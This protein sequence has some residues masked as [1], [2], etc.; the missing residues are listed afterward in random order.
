MCKLSTSACASTLS[1]PAG[2]APNFA[3]SGSPCA[4]AGSNATTD[5][6]SALASRAVSCPIDPKPSKPRVLPEI[7]RPLDSASRGHSPAATAAEEAY[8]P[9]SSTIAVAITYSATLLAFAPVAGNT[10]M[11]CCSQPARSMLSRPTPSRPTTLHRLSDA[12]S[13][14]RTCV[15][16]RTIRAS[17]LA[18]SSHRRGRSSTSFGS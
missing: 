15:R 1:R 9:R 13:S 17:Q 2:A 16:L 6:P 14:P 10:C 18:A 7:S 5:M 8:E 12:S 11:P 3:N 4:N